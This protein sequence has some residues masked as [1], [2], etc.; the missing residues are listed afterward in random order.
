M[1]RQISLWGFLIITILSLVVLTGCSQ[2]GQ[3][4]RFIIIPSD[5]GSYSSEMVAGFQKNIEAAGGEVTV[6]IPKNITAE[7]RSACFRKLKKR[8][9]TVW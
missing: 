4:K 6:E 5:D 3:K 9:Q 7:A 2:D 8:M 1:R